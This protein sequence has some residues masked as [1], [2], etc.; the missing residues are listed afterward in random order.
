MKKTIRGAAALWGALILFCCGNLAPPPGPAAGGRGAD[1]GAPRR[2]Y[3]DGVYQGA[4]EGY[5][6]TVLVELRIEDGAM[7]EIGIVEHEDDEYIGGAAME[8]LLDM[9]LTYNTTDL[10]AISGATESCAG[11]LAALEAALAAAD[12]STLRD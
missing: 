9:V 10:D 2:L 11:F 1:P 8:E 7:A 4:G 6:G 5:R 12:N 3:R